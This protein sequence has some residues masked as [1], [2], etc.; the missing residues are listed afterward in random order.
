M[1]GWLGP[2]R[3][4]SGSCIDLARPGSDWHLLETARS[5]KSDER[6]SRCE[7]HLQESRVGVPSPFQYDDV[8][9]GRFQME[10]TTKRLVLVAHPNQIQKTLDHGTRELFCYFSAGVVMAVDVTT[11]LGS[12]Q[13]LHIIA[14]GQ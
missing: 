1:S 7:V 12:I 9:R 6:G 4:C 2:I 13:Q 14:P 11:Y 8:V 5:G 3:W 10:V